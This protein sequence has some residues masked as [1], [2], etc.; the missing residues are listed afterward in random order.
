[1]KSIVEV[2][3][4]FKGNKHEVSLDLLFDRFID[5]INKD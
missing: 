3:K 4:R 2:L 1:M 5:Y